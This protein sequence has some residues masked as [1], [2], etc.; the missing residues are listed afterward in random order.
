MWLLVKR[1]VRSQMRGGMLTA[2]F[3]VLVIL[4]SSL[5]VMM[6]EHS[7]NAGLVYD[8]FYR[9]TNL[10]DVVVTALPGF[11]YSESDMMAA[12]DNVT[13]EYSGTDLAINRC[14]THYTHREE[15]ITPDGDNI[16]LIAHGFVSGAQVSIPW[17]DEDSG[18]M[19]DGP[20]E[21]AIDR[22]M[23]RHLGIATG[24]Q[25]TLILGGQEVSFN[26]TG[27]AN[28]ANHLFYTVNDGELAMAMGNL[29]VVYMP[30]EELLSN[31]GMETDLRNSML[32]DV[33]GTPDH[34]FH[35]TMANE[36]AELDRLRASLDEEFGARGIDKVQTADRS[37]IW[38]VEAMRQD[39]EGAK[40]T[41]PVFL[42]L[43][44]GISALVMSISLERLVKRQSREIA[45]LRTIGV[46][47]PALL[48]SYLTVPA[49]HGLVGGA[50][51]VWL[52]RHLS[53]AMTEWYFDFIAAMPVV[54]EN[55]YDDISLMVLGSVL[56]ILL[57]FG[58]LP[59]RKA[60]KLSPL[61]VMRQQAGAKP[62]PFVAWATSGM[63]PSVGLGFRSTFKTDD[64]RFRSR[65]VTHPGEQHDDDHRGDAAVGEGD[66]RG[67]DLGRQGRVRSNQQSGATNLGGGE[68]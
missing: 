12:C 32:I 22:N 19:A 14:D 26:V 50:V 15:F 57:L 30:V 24:D 5:C 28:H 27:Y 4:A 55:H 16:T 41:T 61:E 67:R 8:D 31:L 6:W 68:Q 47:S 54:V 35:D 43:L 60:V 2:L 18:E 53:A 59:A 38:S 10:A 17:F 39:L 37:S 58:L 46:K 64:D 33:Q 52:G 34:D 65:P 44:A 9:E 23:F 21:V 63:P 66:P 29:A 13:L 40:K 7:R 49:F 51:G 25:V 45:V 11:R 56:A 62:N 1:L 36:G 48:M 42:V 20:G 3:M